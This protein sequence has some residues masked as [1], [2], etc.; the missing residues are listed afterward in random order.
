MPGTG[1]Q[2][3]AP[4]TWDQVLCTITLYKELVPST[5]NQVLGVLGFLAA[6]LLFQGG[7]GPLGALLAFFSNTALRQLG[8]QKKYLNNNR[9]RSALDSFPRWGQIVLESNLNFSFNFDFQ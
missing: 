4:N 6:C 3:F 1:T 2:Y 7:K 5:W 8:L 9:L